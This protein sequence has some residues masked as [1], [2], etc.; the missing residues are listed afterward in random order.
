VDFLP[1]DAHHRIV[2]SRTAGPTPVKAVAEELWRLLETM[3]T[4][5]IPYQLFAAYDSAFSVVAIDREETLL[6]LLEAAAI[7]WLGER[8]PGAPTH[9]FGMFNRREDPEFADVYVC[10]H[11]EADAA[12]AGSS[13]PGAPFYAEVRFGVGEA[14]GAADLRRRFLDVLALFTPD[15]AFVETAYQ[16]PRAISEATAPRVGWATFVPERLGPLPP[17]DPAATVEPVPGGSLVIATPSALDDTPERE[18]VRASVA[19]VLLP[20][21]E[22]SVAAPY[23]ERRPTEPRLSV[24]LF[25]Q[26]QHAPAAPPEAAAVEP[27]PPPAEPAYE[28]PPS[29]QPAG[30]VARVEVGSVPCFVAGAPPDLRQA[31][32][33]AAA[34]VWSLGPASF[35][36][37]IAKISFVLQTGRLGPTAAEPLVEKDQ[38]YRRSTL[39]SL[40]DHSDMIP[41]LPRAEA[42][43]RG[44]AVVPRGQRVH[45]RFLVQQAPGQAV[46]LDKMIEIR[47]D[48]EPAPRADTGAGVPGHAST[49]YAS[50]PDIV[51]IP[52]RYELALHDD[53]A[54][55]AGIQSETSQTLPK[56]LNPQAE[57]LPIGLGSISPYWPLRANRMKPQDSAA[58]HRSPVDLPPDFSW[59][60]YSAA[61]ANQRIQGYFQGTERLYLEGFH[62][63]DRV[64]DAVLPGASILG[65]AYF[66][67][68]S[69][70]PVPMVADTLRVDLDRRLVSITF[71]GYVAARSP[72]PTDVVFG[73]A[74]VSPGGPLPVWPEQVVFQAEPDASPM[75]NPEEATMMTFPAA[76]AVGSALPFM[77]G[78]GSPEDGAEGP[79]RK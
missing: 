34:I 40:E 52:L 8:P 9:R 75:A 33:R 2:F 30:L 58:F 76:E 70:T 25:M 73:A 11:A 18:A 42:F 38:Y 50:S 57:D 32:A 71:R 39:Q 60:A 68:G 3:K 12:P 19:Y 43:V 51:A 46:L 64:I 7:D 45:A 69:S 28:A 61:P 78:P 53:V 26:P 67:D 1:P 27:S 36:T 56:L 62:T 74:V 6:E 14:T 55:P 63:K 44:T 23:L 24:P 21:L 17:L 54:N 31:P 41:Y 49:P 72:D 22:G 79:K 5:G 65:R 20:F 35:V 16:K 15:Q 10:F 77:G 29:Q 59:D 48:L 66:R 47:G 37:G 4:W 13:A